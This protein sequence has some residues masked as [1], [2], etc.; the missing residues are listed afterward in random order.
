[1]NEYW[2]FFLNKEGR[3]LVSVIT[4]SAFVSFIN[5]QK[6]VNSNKF[7]KDELYIILE[8]YKH[9]IQTAIQIAPKINILSDEN[10]KSLN[11]ANITPR[12]SEVMLTCLASRKEWDWVY[13]NLA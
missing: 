11:L 10:I 9:T 12:E 7:S 6:E 2:D 1:M 8:T 13:R 5:L 4:I 3:E